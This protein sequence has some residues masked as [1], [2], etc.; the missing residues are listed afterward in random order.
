MLLQPHSTILF[1]GELD[2]FSELL[3]YKTCDLV[4][5]NVC[6]I[7]DTLE[8]KNSNSGY[9]TQTGFIY[10]NELVTE[11]QSKSSL[12]QELVE[13]N[14]MVETLQVMV[15]KERKTLV[16]KLKEKENSSN[17]KQI[18]DQQVIMRLYQLVDSEQNKRIELQ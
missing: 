14:K 18:E 1:S 3:F 4:P 10:R 8:Q 2:E 16:D 9:F 11:K 15:E 13:T 5:Q 6:I 12:T 7:W 17:S